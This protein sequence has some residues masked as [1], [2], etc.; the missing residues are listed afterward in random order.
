MHYV[1]EKCEEKENGIVR[2][3][4]DVRKRTKLNVTVARETG[5]EK[6]DT[7]KLCLWSRMLSAGLHDDYDTPKD[8]LMRL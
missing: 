2:D 6:Y 1:V 5:K 7:P 4:S 3:L 8:L